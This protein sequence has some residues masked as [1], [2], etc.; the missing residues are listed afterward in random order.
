M[1]WTLY[2]GKLSTYRALAEEIGTKI[3]THFGDESRSRTT[4]PDV[5]FSDESSYSTP[6]DAVKRFEG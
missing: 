2:G 6:Q 3:C 4:Q 1:M 5:W